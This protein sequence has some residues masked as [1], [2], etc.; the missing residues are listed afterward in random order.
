MSGLIVRWL[1]IRDY[2][3][4]LEAMQAFTAARTPAT[5]DEIWLLEHPPVYTIGVRGHANAPDAIGDIPLVRTDRGGLITYHGPGQLIAYTLIDLARKRISVRDL[6]S[7]LENATVDLLGQYGIQAYPRADAPGVY[8]EGAKIA[9]LGI[10]VK[11]YLSY[12]GLSLNVDLDP[13]PFRAIDPCGFRGM[14]MTRLADLG[15]RVKVHEAAVPLL[16]SLMAQLGFEQVDRTTHELPKSLFQ[17]SIYRTS[18]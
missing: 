13:T 14:E 12:H 9:S 15:A 8:V 10:R 4:A 2:V 5:A 1:G 11:K 7:A 3:E 6:V 17:N 18:L 16:A